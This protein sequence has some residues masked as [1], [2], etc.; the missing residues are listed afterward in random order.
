VLF[1]IEMSERNKV[2]ITVLRRFDQSEVF[3]KSPVKQTASFKI[4]EDFKDG[5]K[6]IVDEDMAI[7]KGFCA[8]AWNTIFG[9]VKVLAFGGD[10]P[11]YAEKGVSISCCSDGLRPVI[12]KLER[13]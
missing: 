6:F 8:Y 2:K 10:F 3:K 9:D 7:P 11:W 13:V 4:C 1:V 5:Q 12:F